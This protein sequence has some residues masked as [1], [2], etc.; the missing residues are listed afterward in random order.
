MRLVLFLLL[1]GVGGALLIVSYWQTKYFRRS[2]IVTARTKHLIGLLL[3]FAG[4]LVF[5]SQ[6][7][8]HARQ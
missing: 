5:V 8:I 2:I 3:I 1:T 6:F 4:L 7:V